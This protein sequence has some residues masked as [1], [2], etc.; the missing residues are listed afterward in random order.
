MDQLNGDAADPTGG[1]DD[2]HHLADL[3]RERVK[4]C[5]RGGWRERGHASG[6]DIDGARARGDVVLVHH[7]LFSPCT[8]VYGRPTCGDGTEHVI[9]GSDGGDA[10]ADRFDGAGEVTAES[11]RIDVHHRIESREEG[12]QCN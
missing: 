3:R 8:R 5:D 2:E 1:A 10:V 11:N 12:P 9:A 7:Y 4:G 6:G